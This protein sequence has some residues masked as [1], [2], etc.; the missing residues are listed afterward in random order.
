[1]RRTVVTGVA[2][3]LLLA[4]V[5]GCGGD[6]DLGVPSDA[7][8]DAGKSIAINPSDTLKKKSQG[9]ENSKGK[10]ATP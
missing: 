8:P 4:V 1:M 7:S 3:A 9:M 10:P 6:T 2:G 5:S